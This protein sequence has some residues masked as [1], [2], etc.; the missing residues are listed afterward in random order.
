M[1]TAGIMGRVNYVGRAETE[2]W[3]VLSDWSI[4]PLSI[5]PYK[6]VHRVEAEEGSFCLKEVDRRLSRALALEG[7][8]AHLKARGFTKIAMAHET[9]NGRL[10]SQ[11]SN[12]RNYILTDWLIGRKPSFRT[13]DEDIVDAAVAL[14]EF[15]Q[16][17]EGYTPPSGGKLRNRLN[18]WPT[19]FSSRLRQ[20][21]KLREQLE[22][23]PLLD[24]FDRLFV[25]YYPWI[26]DR[27][28]EGW[29]VLSTSQ[30][31]NLV[32]AASEARSF[33]HG[34]TAER[35]FVITP[36]DGCCLID[37]DLLRRDIR[38]ADVYK[39]IRDVLKKRQWDF[40]SA[41]LI[42]DSYSSAAPL[43]LEELIV[44]YA[45]LAYPH[46]VIHLILRYYVKREGKSSTWPARKFIRKLQGLG[47][48][49]PAVDRFLQD[50]RSEYGIGK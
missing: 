9:K 11:A 38:I 10:I 5:S 42:L 3:M 4:T 35:N 43:D 20:L 16:A 14:A 48:Q 49:Q 12:G 27:A 29:C 39:L 30:Y 24:N 34:D 2:L 1:R 41:K 8:L 31:D 15:H 7:V 22:H 25:E 37:L 50:F 46:K 19:R 40:S 21:V 47:E 28:Q 17:S 44:L 45:M 18:R 23:K 13:S 36:E 33:C 32:K 26:L 6:D